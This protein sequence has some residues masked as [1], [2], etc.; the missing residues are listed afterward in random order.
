[1]TRFAEGLDAEG[2]ISDATR[3]ALLDRVTITEYPPQGAVAK[4]VFSSDD[5]RTYSAVKELLGDH[6]SVIT[7]TMPGLGTAG[8]EVA[9]AGVTKG[10]ALVETVQT[11]GL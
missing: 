3:E 1:Y 11:L 4:A 9:V 7:G 2:R 8:G 6:F 5:Q 10:S